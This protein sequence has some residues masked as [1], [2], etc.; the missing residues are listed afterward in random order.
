MTETPMHFKTINA[1]AGLIRSKQLS[2]VE[3]THA[4]PGR[5]QAL[6]GRLKSYVTVMA[7]HALPSAKSAEEAIGQGRYS[8]PIH[9]VPVAVKDLCFTENVPTMAGK[10]GGSV[11]PISMKP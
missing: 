10:S 2:P 11:S 8:V 5:I 7:E 9:G 4:M 6:G 3:V 1:L